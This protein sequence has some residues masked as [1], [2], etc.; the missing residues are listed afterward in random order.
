MITLR[1]VI[2]NGLGKDRGGCIAE[3]S[4]VYLLFVAWVFGTQRKLRRTV[5]DD[6]AK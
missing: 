6:G 1:R 5:S 4:N 2:H 3:I